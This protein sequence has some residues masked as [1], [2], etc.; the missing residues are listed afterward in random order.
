ME[1]VENQTDMKNLSK[2]YHIIKGLLNDLKQKDDYTMSDW[3]YSLDSHNTK[4]Q[5]KPCEHRRPN[6]HLRFEAS[7][8]YFN[9]LYTLIE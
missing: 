2:G 8:K 5:L 9:D 4:F 1:K 3:I 7:I 6:I